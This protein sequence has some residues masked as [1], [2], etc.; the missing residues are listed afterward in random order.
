MQD[1]SRLAVFG[2]QLI[3]VVIVIIGLLTQQGELHSIRPQSRAKAPPGA[4]TEVKPDIFARLWDDPFEDMQRPS[5]IS[6]EQS[7]TTTKA[8]AAVE[9]HESPSPAE[10]PSATPTPAPQNYTFLWNIIDAAPW[11]DAKERRLRIRYAVVSA[12][13]AEGYRPLRASVLHSLQSCVGRF[14]TFRKQGQQNVCVIWTPKLETKLPIEQDELGNIKKDISNEEKVQ[15]EGDVHV[16]H[17]GTSQ[18]LYNYLVAPSTA[19]A[20]PPQQRILFMRATIP[21]DDLELGTASPQPNRP[22]RQEVTTD[23]KLVDKLFRELCARI[24]AMNDKSRPPRVVVFTESD[25]IYSK[26]IVRELKKRLIDIDAKPEVYSYLQALD[27][28]PEAPRAASSVEGSKAPDIATSLLQ[29]KSI[30]ET[31]FGTSQFDYLRRAALG[32]LGKENRRARTVAAVGVLGSDIYDKML[33]LQAV[34]PSLPSA[35]FFTTDLDALY[36][37]REMQPF[38]RNLVVAAADDLN[39]NESSHESDSQW[40]LPPMRDSYQ[41]VLVKEVRNILEGQ[42]SENS[43]QARI[44]EIASGK[45]IELSPSGQPSWPLRLLAQWSF[46][47]VIFLLALGNGLLILWA[48][49][50]RQSKPGAPMTPRAHKFVRVEII[51]ACL[52]LLFLLY[53]LCL[54]DASSLFGEPLILGIGIWPSVMIR[55]LA[56]LVAIVLLSFASHSF[57]AEGLP[58]N[59]HLKHAL[60]GQVKFRSRNGLWGLW[61]KSVSRSFDAFAKW[62]FD[63]NLRRRRIAIVSLVYLLVSFF[64]FARWPPA[65]PARGALPLLIEK[66][67]LSLGVALYIIHLIFCLDLHVSAFSLLR[68]IRLRYDLP[69]EKRRKKPINETEMVTALGTLTAVIGKTLLYPLTVLIL[70][71]LSRLQIFDNWVMT[72]SLTITFA[73][74]AVV[75]VGASLLLWYQGARLEKILVGQ[76]TI[77]PDQK[78]KLAAVDFGVFARWYNQ[79]IFA[80]ILS[81][82]AVFGSVTVVGL[83]TR[84]FVGGS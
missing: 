6:K 28:R 31:S 12:I 18:D 51:L 25:S 60:A 71:I 76:D 80:A 68:N 34:R 40:K 14:E 44:F 70:I 5:T 17:H 63:P 15:A 20:A 57:V 11:P 65:V 52:G 8:T 10:S 2:S 21:L 67:V 72:P 59:K 49:T 30:S 16:L 7:N 22:Y 36:L 29:G 42:G 24:P 78:E 41:T 9:S 81:A 56:F 53:M 1:E 4:E 82:V 38:T 69:V 46:N 19:K 37:E 45:A 39:V 13:L 66:I 61:G 58:Q 48:I 79:P 77:Q 26:A 64:L 47:I 23:D 54:S 83:L 62:A 32:F 35:V 43:K 74:G 3:G 55:L 27:G 33:V 73:I 84:L 50:T 75:L